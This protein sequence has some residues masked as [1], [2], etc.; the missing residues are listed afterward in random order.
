MN[1][2]KLIHIGGPEN[3]TAKIAAKFKIPLKDLKIHRAK[4]IQDV[5]CEAKVIL[6]EKAKKAGINRVVSDVEALDNIISQL[7]NIMEDVTVQDVIRA[8][9]L[10]SELLGDVKKEE[11]LSISWLEDDAE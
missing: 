7:P 8:I 1:I 4:H 5:V 9:K 6:D 3:T 10:K 11:T 2:E